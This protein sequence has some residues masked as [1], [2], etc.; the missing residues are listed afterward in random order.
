[1]LE[2]Q[3]KKPRFRDRDRDGI[4]GEKVLKAIHNLGMQDKP[5]SSRSPWQNGYCERMVGTLKRECLNHM[6]I[7][8][9]RHARRIIGGFFNITAM[10]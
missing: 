4:Y 9:E 3:V 8:N 2:R 7:F 1:M 10:T 6:I 5:A